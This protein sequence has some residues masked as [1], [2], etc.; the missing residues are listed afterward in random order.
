MN[1]CRD[2]FYLFPQAR[3]FSIVL[4]VQ[5]DCAAERSVAFL[6]LRRGFNILCA[7]LL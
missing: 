7:S 5:I 1:N 4:S 3:A 2:C 6:W